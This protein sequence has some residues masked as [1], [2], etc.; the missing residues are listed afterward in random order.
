MEHE[1]VLKIVKAIN[2]NTEALKEATAVER[3]K[4]AIFKELIEVL[5]DGK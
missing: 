2:K 4:N 5:K 1:E 3:Q